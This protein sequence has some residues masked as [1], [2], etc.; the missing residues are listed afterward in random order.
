MTNNPNHPSDDESLSGPAKASFSTNRDPY[1]ARV[2]KEVAKR[3]TCLNEQEIKRILLAIDDRVQLNG[4]ISQ[5][6]IANFV[7]AVLLLRKNQAAQ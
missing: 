6:N 1:R 4:R 7:D 2:E 3:G 5:D